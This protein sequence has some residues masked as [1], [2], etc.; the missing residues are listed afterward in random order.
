MFLETSKLLLFK[1]KRVDFCQIKRYLPVK[2]EFLS[3][4]FSG[5]RFIAL[6]DPGR[7]L[8]D[9]DKVDIQ[10]FQHLVFRVLQSHCN[11][12]FQPFSPLLER[13]L[14]TKEINL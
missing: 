13:V 7:L 1:H 5:Q 3:F 12:K 14:K 4:E 11:N 6:K 9:I 8:F 2:P 10:I